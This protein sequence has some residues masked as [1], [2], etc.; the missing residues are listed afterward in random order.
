[1]SS[2]NEGIDLLK[3]L[4]GKYINDPF[5]EKIINKLNEFRNFEVENSL[6]YL[7]EKE[8]KALCIPKVIVRGQSAQ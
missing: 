5:Y 4:M 6:V 2:S 1:M 7:K 3:E 8:T